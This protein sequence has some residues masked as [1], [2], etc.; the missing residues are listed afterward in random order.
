[1][2]LRR[3]SALAFL[4]AVFLIAEPLVHS[5][6]LPDASVCA[7]CAAGIGQLPL[8]V[9]TVGAPNRIVYTLIVAAFT[10]VVVT[11]ELPLASR[12]PPAA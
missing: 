6:A 2:G 4:L 1:M 9:P 5:H 12:A 3:I 8:N 10:T 7:T 11:I